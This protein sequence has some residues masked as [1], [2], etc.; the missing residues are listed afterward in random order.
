[1]RP[2]GT[3]EQLEA[4]RLLAARRVV[5]DGMKPA[6][7]A[8]VLGVHRQS[9]WLWARRYRQGGAEALAAKKTPGRPAK[10]SPDQ[11]REVLSW[12]SRP[13]SEFGFT[14][15]WWTAPRAAKLID[16]KFGVSPNPRYLNAWLARRRITPQKPA[17]KP[18]ERND[19]AVEAWRG[20][21]WPELL[22]KAERRRPP[23]F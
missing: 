11:E 13:A 5:E 3:Q 8:E 6:Q 4:R 20:E 10:L 2:Q 17:K 21:R 22:K 15:D 23:S 16:E 1:M 7:V 18:R 14:G 19:A 12:F 9:V